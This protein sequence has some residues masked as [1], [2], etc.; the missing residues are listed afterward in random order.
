MDLGVEWL[1]TQTVNTT[2]TTTT[3]TNNNNNNNNNNIYNMSD[4]LLNI[5]YLI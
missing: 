3:T 5:V 4:I 2:T 1:H